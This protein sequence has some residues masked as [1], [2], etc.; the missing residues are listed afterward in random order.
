MAAVV[1]GGS[2]GIQQTSLALL[3]GAGQIGT[4]SQGR[5]GERVYVNAA[6]GNLVLQDQ[7]E[8]L[9]GRG[10]DAAVLRTYNSRGL[11]DDDNGDN[12]R[13]GLYRRVY[14]LTGTVNTAGSTITRTD[15]DGAD[16]VYTYNATLGKYVT[17]EGA[18]AFDTLSYTVATQ[19]W[20]WTDGD[21]GVT[22]TYDGANAGRLTR[23]TDP[24]GNALTYAYTGSLLTSVQTASGETTYLDYTGTNLT[25]VRTVNSA[26][27]TIA[28]TSYTYDASNRLSSVTT[29]LTPD[30]TTDAK[31][32]VTSYTYDGTSRRV[33][34][35]TQTDG[36]SLTFAYT[37]VG[38][39]YRVSQIS[40][41][42][43]R[44]TRFTYD[45]V[46]RTT[47]V[48]DP[49]NG[50]TVLAY[51]ASSR[52]TRVT[53]PPAAGA[54]AQQLNYAYDAS[55][56]VASVTDAKG[57]TVVYGYD[58]NGNRIYE[59]D[60][61]NNVVERVYG[62]RNE[63]LAETQYTT[64]DPDAAGPG[65]PSG[66]L[67]TRYVYDTALRLRFVVSAAGR[68]TENRYSGFG[69]RTSSIQY[70]ANTY[71][72]TGLTPT[73]TLTEA[74]LTAWLPADRSKSVRVDTAYDF[75]SQVS[76]VTSYASVDSAG[77]GVVATKSVAQLIYDQA[78]NLLKTVDARGTATAQAG[79]FE[80]NYVYD[81]MG[82]VLS[83]TDALGN[84]TVNDYQ[85]ANRKTVVSLANGLVRTSTYSAAGELVS[86]LES[87]GGVGLGETKYFYDANSRLR[88]TE[89]PTGVR[90]HILY[91]E[92]GRKVGEI[93]GDGSLTEY[94]YDANNNL[95]RTIEY[96]TAVSAA[97]LASL[98]DASGN[99]TSVALAA[100]RPAASAA[101]RSAW[102]AY[103]TAGRLVKSVDEAGY[104]TQA[105]YD[106]ASRLTDSVRFATAISTA[107]LGDTPAPSAIAP[108]TSA[109]DRLTRSFYDTEGKLLG[110]LDGEGYL[111]ETKYDAAGQRVE[112]VGYATATSASLRTTGTLDQLRPATAATDIHSYTLYNASGQVVGAI[113]AEG[114]LTETVYDATGNKTQVVRYATRV[115]YTAGATLASLRPAANAQ[116]QATSY[117]YDALNQLV[118]QTAPDG[119]VSQF[120]YDNVGNL[121][122]SVKAAGTA[123][124][125]T[126]NAR[127]DRQGRLTGELSGNGA[128]LLTGGQTQ[129]QID[130]IW[131]QY[132]VFHTY[133]A[134]GRRTSSTDALG[135]K[136][137]F[138]YNADGRLVYTINALG[139]VKESV[140][141]ALGDLVQSVQYA[142]RVAASAF[143][144]GLA[145]ASVTAAVQAIADPL[146]DTRVSYG[147][148][149]RGKLVQTTDALGNAVS[150]ALNAFGEVTSKSQA[151]GGGLTLDQ[152]YSYDR[153]GL[154]TQT[155]W[156]PTDLNTSAAT[157]Y[158][159]FGRAVQTTDARG[160][161]R[162][163]TYDRLGQVVSTRDPL[164][165]LRSTTYDA[166]GRVLTQTD[167]L[168]KTTSF[169]YD[170][171]NRS[172]RMT[173][174]EGIV[175]TTVQNRHGQKL[176][177]TD[178][179]GNA[180]SYQYDKN[181]NL[182][183]VTAPGT[184]TTTSTYD[185]ADR[186]IEAV[187]PRGVR[188]TYAYD[189]ANRV[190]KRTLDPAGLALATSY[191]YD[192]KGQ[193]VSVVDANGVET[194]T[195]YDRN[196][197]VVTALVDPNG[198]RLQTTYTYD[199]RGKKLTVTEASN[200]AAPR[201]TQYAYDKLGRLLSAR[202]DPAGLN[203]TTSYTYD[204]NDNVAT[205][206]DANGYVTRYAYDANDRPVYAVDPLGGVTKS[207]YDAEGRITRFTA[208]ATPISLA[209]LPALPSV[210]DIAARVVSSA[211][212]QTKSYV[213]DGDGRE[214]YCIDALGGVTQKVYDADGNVIRKVQYATPIALSTPLTIAGVQAALVANTS[215]QTVRAIY[216][217]ANR[218]IYG[219][220]ASGAVTLSLY[221]GNSN[222]TRTRALAAPITLGGDLTKAQLEAVLVF[223]DD[224]DRI[225]RFAYD[226]ANR[227]VYAVDGEGFVKETRYDG[228]GRITQTLQY[229]NPIAV[230]TLPTVAEIAAALNAIA[231]PNTVAASYGNQTV[232]SGQFAGELA[233]PYLY[234]PTAKA[235]TATVNGQAVT[236]SVSNGTE[237]QSSSVA[238]VSYYRSGNLIYQTSGLS[239]VPGYAPAGDLTPTQV[240][241][242]IYQGATQVAQTYTDV[243]YATG[244]QWQVWYQYPTAWDEYNN[245]IAWDWTYYWAS[246]TRWNN[247]ANWGDQVNLTAGNL[248][249]G[250]YRIVLETWDSA[251]SA[252]ANGAF[253]DGTDE[254]WAYS[255]TLNDVV[256]G[257]IDRPT[258]LSW[259]AATQ[260]T[261]TASMTFEY[262][263]AG[264][265][266]AYTSATIAV[267]GT[268]H[269]VSL[270]GLANGNYEYRIQYKDSYGR[271]LKSS[272]GTFTSTRGGSSSVAA[273]F[274]YTVYGSAAA[275]G[276]SIRYF[277]QASQW[278]PV[279][280]INATVKDQAGNVV[281]TAVTYPEAESGYNGEVNLKTGAALADGRYTIELTVF[282]KDGST[283]AVTPF[284]YE[285]GEQLYSTRTTT[286]KWSAAGQ[287]AGTTASFAY[288]RSGQSGE[289]LVTPTLVNGNYV[290]TF[291]FSDRAGAQTGLADG[292]YDYTVRYKNAAQAVVAQARGQFI[293]TVSGNGSSTLDF[294]GT[295]VGRERTN[296][297]L[298][299]HGGRLVQ[300]TDPLGFNESYTYDALGNKTSFT[301][302]KGSVWTYAYDMAGRLVEEVAPAVTVT[303]A[304]GT[305][306]NAVALH[307]RIQYDAL[308]NVISRTEAFGR[309]EARMTQYSYDALGR[310]QRT[311]YPTVNIY[312]AAADNLGTNTGAN[313]TETAATLYAEVTYDSLGRAVVNRAVD[314][315]NSYK[316]YDQE[317][318]L[319]YDID[320]E[321]F[322]TEHR[323]DA[324]GNETATIRYAQ[325]LAFGAHATAAAWSLAD[326][327]AGISSSAQDRRID[328]RYDRNQRLTEVIEPQS[329]VFD[330][331][332]NTGTTASRRTLSE[333][334]AFGQLTRQRA[335]A[336]VDAAGNSTWADTYSYFDGRGERTAQIDAE[337]Y[338][339]E[340]QYDAAGNVSRQTEY[341]KRAAAGW[342]NTG[343]VKPQAG[344]ADSGYDR[345]T[346]YAY[347]LADHKVSETLVGV[348]FATIEN[349][350]S[351]RDASGDVTTTY[352]Y[353][354][355]GN[356]V[357]T[358]DA[359]GNATYTYYDSLGRTTAVAA[360]ARQTTDAAHGN[361]VVRPLT[362]F[363]LD[364]FGKTVRQTDYFSGATSAS[365]SGYT[366]G[367]A[368]AADKMSTSVYDAHGNL[369]QAT[370]AEG[371]STYASYDA[372]GRIAKTWQPITEFWPGSGNLTQYR[373]QTFQYDADG[374]QVATVDTSTRWNYIDPARPALGNL[375]ISISSGIPQS[376]SYSQTPITDEFGTITGYQDNWQPNNTINVNWGLNLA[377]LGSGDVY[378]QVGYTRVSG[379]YTELGFSLGGGTTTGATLSWAD[380]HWTT[381]YGV[382]SINRVMVYKRNTAGTLVLIHDT[383]VNGWSSNLIGAQLPTTGSVSLFSR[384]SGTTTWNPAAMQNFGAM[385]LADL[386]GTGSLDFETRLVTS[387]AT[388]AYQRGALS[389]GA[390]TG[391]SSIFNEER[392][393]YNA[394]GEIASK[395]VDGRQTEYFDYDSAGHIWRTNQKDGVDKVYL[396]DVQGK[397]SAEI[398]SLTADLKTY[399][400]AAAADTATRTPGAA[401]RTE[402]QYDKLERA[403]R[404]ELPAFG[405]V[406][407]TVVRAPAATASS[408]SASVSNNGF[409][410]TDENGTSWSGTGYVSASWSSLAGWGSGAIT[411]V[412]DVMTTTHGQIT[413]SGGGSNTGATLSVGDELAYVVR[414]RVYMT[415]TSGGQTLVHDSNAVNSRRLTFPSP[416]TGQASDYSVLRYKVTG[417]QTWSE[418]TAANLGAVSMVDTTGWANGTYD[419][420]VVYR[421]ADGSTFAT[422]T[423]T[424]TLSGTSAVV[425]AAAQ[426][427]TI[428]PVNALTLDRWGNTLSQVDARIATDST[429][430]S[431]EWE[432]RYRYDERNLLLSETAPLVQMQDASGA[433]SSIRPVTRNFY[434]RLGRAI[435]VQDPNAVAAD[436]N[437][438][439]VYEFASTA[440]YNGAGQ[441][442]RRFDAQ[443][444]VT[445]YA[446]D[447]FGRQTGEWDARGY[448]TSSTYD[449]DDRLTQQTRPDGTGEVYQYDALGN[450][451]AVMD[452]RGYWTTYGYDAFGRLLR[453]TLPNGQTAWSY[454]DQAG[455]KTY[456]VDGNGNAQSWQYD[457]FGHAMYYVDVSGTGTT[458]TYTK[459][460]Q[461]KTS[462]NWRSNSTNTYDINGALKRV[463][464]N[465]LSPDN[466]NW[467]SQSS[468]YEYDAA[469]NRTRETYT[470]WGTVYSDV[471]TSYDALNRVTNVTDLRYSLQY[472]YDANGNR[473]HTTSNFFNNVGTPTTKNYWYTYDRA[474]RI[475]I[476]QGELSAGAIV[477]GS[478][479]TVLTY[480]GAGNRAT[481]YGASTGW[482]TEGYL[483]D[484]DGRLYQ[485]NRNG[486]IASYR[487]YDAADNVNTLYTYN[488]SGAL[489][490]YQSN[491]Y[492]ANGWL[493]TQTNV[494][495]LYY[496]DGGG[497]SYV[498]DGATSQINY[499]GR[500]GTGQVS[501]YNISVW[502]PYVTDQ[503]SSDENGFHPNVYLSN[504]FQYTNYYSYAYTGYGSSLKESVVYGSSSYF[505]P[506]TTTTRYDGNGS[507]Y[508]VSDQFQGS[509]YR[510]FVTDQTGR[511]LQKSQSGQNEYYFYANDKPLG[512]TG[513]GG[514]AD[515]DFNY[516]PVSDQYPASTPSGYVAA[517]GDTL[518]SI[519][520]QVYGDGGLWYLI[521]DANGISSDAQLKVGMDLKVPNRITNLHNAYDTFKP[522]EPGKIVGDTTPTLP[523][524]PP[525][526][527]PKKKHGLFGGFGKILMIIVAVVAAVFTAGAA[528]AALAPTLGIGLAGTTWGI[529]MAA[530]TG[531]FAGTG[532]AG[533]AIAAAAIGGAVGSIASQLVGMATGDVEKFSWSQVALSAVGSGVT[534]G[535][536]TAGVGSSLFAKNATAALMTNAAIGNAASQG[537]A[538]ALGMQ[539]KFNWRSV[540]ATAIATPIATAI[541][542]AVNEAIGK[543][544]YGDFAR[545]FVGGAVSQ[546]IRSEFVS[547][548]RVDYEQIAADSFGNL[549]ADSLVDQMK[550]S[551]Q[552][553]WLERANAD[554]RASRSVI[555]NQWSDTGEEISI[556]PY[557]ALSNTANSGYRL[558]DSDEVAAASARRAAETRAMWDQAMGTTISDAAP[559]GYKAGDVLADA[560]AASTSTSPG[561]NS[562]LPAG[563]EE[564]IVDA[565]CKCRD[566]VAPTWTE[567]REAAQPALDYFFGEDTSAEK[568]SNLNEVHRR[569]ACFADEF[570]KSGSVWFGN[571]PDDPQVLVEVPLMRGADGSF[572]QVPLSETGRTTYDGGPLAPASTARSLSLAKEAGPGKLTILDM[573]ILRDPSQPAS[574]SNIDKFIEL[575]FEGDRWTPNQSIMLN[576]ADAARKVF[577]L[578]ERDVAAECDNR[579]ED[580]RRQTQR[581]L[582]DLK[583]GIDKTLPFWP[584]V[585]PRRPVP[586]R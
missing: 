239:I 214:I 280:H 163:T 435:G 353:D 93:D 313:R 464:N 90:M 506:G 338:L 386:R 173:T 364:V 486:V 172:V 134:A 523:N 309:P 225:Q 380:N 529:G 568:A 111:I 407:P 110:V 267:S 560:S 484:S 340:W 215:D 405:N 92:A 136:T 345:V 409:W 94:R 443:G 454:Y 400:N 561:W 76:T 252:Q 497:N 306:E 60:A 546:T 138:Y 465:A 69:E 518:R 512:A 297:F 130:T 329:Y 434:D 115:T 471:T 13:I 237:F 222:V 455:N 575:K 567:T 412:A 270:S 337:G 180:T 61:A 355:V 525:P 532:L 208:Y 185:A 229:A 424:L 339:T 351:L 149:L 441:V 419:Y 116:D 451:T 83:T 8:I 295:G 198:L 361:T 310:Q 317:G 528:L 203:L 356:L 346:T 119:T 41:A 548:G 55:G 363:G 360:P 10:P 212:D 580:S 490:G 137:R 246:G 29:D 438:N 146:R 70:T 298:Y 133:D 40:D 367:A 265:T 403:V 504:P 19:T 213:Y 502:N 510:S 375:G 508:D 63:L 26:A 511:I 408:A 2:L 125:R 545:R 187:D 251:Q 176:S 301:N 38:S 279:D 392:A 79:D 35:M 77:N 250:H 440:R 157:V 153:R 581:F 274:N 88:R 460:G 415:N 197:Q 165:A 336:S 522:Y 416:A 334:N 344:D 255:N 167:A 342:T 304:S 277:S 333:Y 34:G 100:I 241:A 253:Y 131:A 349:N 583:D 140:Y 45:T 411:V 496:T 122:S 539:D 49:L 242:T 577:R 447:V 236:L 330:S 404:N 573:A 299:D 264:S 142:K 205:K 294:G 71:N 199:A 86:V 4:A 320:G 101:D 14:A 166:F 397:A 39:D 450:R 271:A 169:V 174:P 168:G 21:T 43:G 554:T 466:V 432:K 543:N 3:G 564:K 59:R 106:G 457:Q 290:V 446:Y 515:F 544:V 366:A 500:T 352:G 569:Q 46:A 17:T 182:T 145:D 326:V 348:H 105:F 256:I 377:S 218:P 373:I 184:G 22:E 23:V 505:Q 80:T 359:D 84:L 188:T 427:Q 482:V 358:T 462:T 307:P 124:V 220:D 190:L 104:V 240:R 150:Q 62:S 126:I 413:L 50:I 112:T 503:S 394:F 54:P 584:P 196:G 531:G 458:Y 12:W 192:G 481:A 422:G 388:F 27:V 143:S 365:A 501:S 247:V 401:V 52:L 537:V 287:P 514:A 322:V 418:V 127:F 200:T 195:S 291:T 559:T 24:S 262:R 95:T 556:R 456:A 513:A 20:T 109:A 558:P 516:T 37:L 224:T 179:R 430:T 319:R 491:V 586:I 530:I 78:G 285:T 520:Q 449:R 425:A 141:N 369:I 147:Y 371:N 33:A 178:G 233:Q 550:L 318:H 437:N 541:G 487:S 189:A 129:A 378:V 87:S 331:V 249:P 566:K 243:G 11:M 221:D 509:N 534:A 257:T 492:D 553:E 230:G 289:T 374:N 82:R 402:T 155:V 452:G 245:P 191:V 321:H 162:T 248:A 551:G 156:D 254:T 410:F 193:A 65:L 314:G 565:V 347:D 96:A 235:D 421:H 32:Y 53:M 473:R 495:R 362:T 170:T 579:D 302:K 519:A 266:G 535:V 30:N 390:M 368:N 429:P 423:G 476:S 453:Q 160:N 232:Q 489:T 16:A 99:P 282:N 324:F 474:N 159:A 391:A 186:L 226:A 261:G 406:D 494:K 563:V 206:T 120:T 91:D 6:T 547:G 385:T 219:I 51:D 585:G 97:N 485:T 542:G 472:T 557:N 296:S 396:Y 107:T 268:N 521:A 323:Y 209:G 576:D 555:T 164:N 117:A 572:S 102:N 72:L 477:V 552:E 175:V 56:N 387:D 67:T 327:A 204:K 181:G 73:S 273:T 293:A 272:N 350:T 288:V 25:R 372:A 527:P 154:L 283:T 7:D 469:G 223:N 524:P 357:S 444:Q 332:S 128:A 9:V 57:N 311:T 376:A 445:D 389:G 238:N 36:T 414:V 278:A 383:N 244:E 303:S 18:G 258:I 538:I 507:I 217:A 483:Y 171:V 398:K 202:V 343:Y 103:D 428:V 48:T 275:A 98:V 144:G 121:I 582:K 431:D 231:V 47:T 463:D 263:A 517:A 135:N 183:G 292:I 393:V 148:D 379:G 533:A 381:G 108:S 216:D 28:R 498:F 325:R 475:L 227:Q 570:I 284:L 420:Q 433:T 123:E 276:T 370:D 382:S 459:L 114:A 81:G 436:T 207:E 578:N 461:V 15:A 479:G 151:L 269:Q 395:T 399:A 259:A 480:D 74:Q 316:V 526:P 152:V 300:S 211:S 439:G 201:L 417:T 194:R 132:G 468:A 234:L 478:Q 312:N 58:A 426:V 286:V 228:L 488:S 64:P 315:V 75:R 499:T 493:T 448:L 281:S 574:F 158:D 341:A 44:I 66:A 1:S 210:A 384:V 139:E 536:A 161:V 89:D 85:D 354:A 118:S 177:V 335:L 328:K 305:V 42:L 562:N 470:K 467:W 5:A 31:T 549:A 113:D 308:G 260:P 540:A 68:V 571:R 442:T